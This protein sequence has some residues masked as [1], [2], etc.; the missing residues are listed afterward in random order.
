MAFLLPNENINNNTNNNLFLNQ[1]ETIQQEVIIEQE[2]ILQ[3]GVFQEEKVVVTSDLVKD[4]FNNISIVDTFK[5]PILEA[6]SKFDKDINLKNVF[7]EYIIQ[8]INI[9]YF[10]YLTNIFEYDINLFKEVLINGEYKSDPN[11]KFIVQKL[12]DIYI[13]Q[14]A[15]DPIKINNL[16]FSENYKETELHK[17]IMD[18]SFN[19]MSKLDYSNLTDVKH[20]NINN[21]ELTQNNIPKLLNVINEKYII[22]KTEIF[23][24][25][26]ILVSQ[27][28]EFKKKI[29]VL[30]KEIN[31]LQNLQNTTELNKEI[32]K[33]KNNS[34]YDLNN[35]INLNIIN[36]EKIKN[37]DNLEKYKQLKKLIKNNEDITLFSN[38]YRLNSLLYFLTRLYP[39]IIYSLLILNKFNVRDAQYRLVMIKYIQRQT[40]FYINYLNN[41]FISKDFANIDK[42]IEI[43]PFP[44]YTTVKTLDKLFD[45]IRSNLYVPYKIINMFDIPKSKLDDPKYLSKLFNSVPQYTT[46]YFTTDNDKNNY[47]VNKQIYKRELNKK[48]LFIILLL[49]IAILFFKVS[50]KNHHIL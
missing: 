36:I 16:I 32:I 33:S 37:N 27:N 10:N 2:N 40:F 12:I 30:N 46:E 15:N 25:Y 1:E 20:K 8:P 9:E 11:I 50:Y 14:T 5:K 48:Y 29:N 17:L 38:L 43:T 3:E 26:S 7:N 22:D 28:E 41:I 45:E 39:L 34:I 21:F 18:L 6:I 24:N 4:F 19:D 13:I 49:L 35:T 44:N 31:I 23:N 42:N 47:I